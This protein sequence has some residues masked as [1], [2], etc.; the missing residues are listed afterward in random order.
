[1]KLP[2][3]TQIITVLKIALLNTLFVPMLCLLYAIA[4]G[5][6]YLNLADFLWWTMQGGIVVLPVAA[7]YAAIVVALKWRR[8][9]KGALCCAMLAAGMVIAVIVAGEMLADDDWVE[10]DIVL[11]GA[12]IAGLMGAISAAYLPKS[13]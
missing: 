9:V 2:N 12:A 8:N 13:A 6:L 10:W 5:D 11:V 4:H 3:R 1:M 7:V